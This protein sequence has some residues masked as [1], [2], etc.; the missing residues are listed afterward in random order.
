[1]PK[2]AASPLAVIRLAEQGKWQCRA[3]SLSGVIRSSVTTKRA[4]SEVPCPP[5]VGLES[6]EAPAAGC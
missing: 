4:S 1:M 6:V 3:S 5:Q 2:L